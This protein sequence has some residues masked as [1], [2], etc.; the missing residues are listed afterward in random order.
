MQDSNNNQVWPKGYRL[1][2]TDGAKVLP[3][4]GQVGLYL[5]LACIHQMAPPEHTSDKQACYSVVEVVVH[6]YFYS[7]LQ[8]YL[9]TYLYCRVVVQ[10]S[11][12]R[13]M[14]H[15]KWCVGVQLQQQCGRE[16]CIVVTNLSRMCSE[17][18]NTE[19]CPDLPIRAAVRMSM[20]FPRE[21][22]RNRA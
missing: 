2:E 13:V 12:E 5:A 8:I 16:L 1:P 19:T 10:S 3:T 18:C 6:C 17:Y 7:A 4:S 20:A 9:L 15:D 11:C 22:V 21:S 14:L